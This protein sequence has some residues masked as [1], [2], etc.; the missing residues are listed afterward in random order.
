VKKLRK[1]VN[2]CQSYRKNKSGTFF[3]DHSVYS[4]MP[5]VDDAVGWAEEGHPACR[6]TEWWNAV[7]VIY[8]G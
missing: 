5:S 7:V 4:N 6:K 1:S 8:L 2:I 3:M